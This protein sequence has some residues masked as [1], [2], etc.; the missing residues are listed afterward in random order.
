MENSSNTYEKPILC[1]QCQS[2]RLMVFE[3]LQSLTLQY[4][5]EN[6]LGK[7]QFILSK[8]AKLTKYFEN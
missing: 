2:R 7:Y 4:G 6:I 3:N 5:V 8:F 1:F